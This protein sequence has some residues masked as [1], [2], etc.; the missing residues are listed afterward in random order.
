MHY[1]FDG[2]AIHCLWTGSFAPRRCR[3][4]AVS[5]TNHTFLVRMTT[6]R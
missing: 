1:P 4:F 2:P 6:M 3:R 5:W